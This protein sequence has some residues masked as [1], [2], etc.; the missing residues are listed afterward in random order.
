ME[1]PDIQQVGR[2]SRVCSTL[3]IYQF[4]EGKTDNLAETHRTDI[5]RLG[6][7]V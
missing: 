1:G 6:Y 5:I 7:S 3:S 4:R 2:R